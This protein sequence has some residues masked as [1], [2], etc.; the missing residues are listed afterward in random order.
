[1]LPVKGN[2]IPCFCPD[3]SLLRLT[4][5]RPIPMSNVTVIEIYRP[6][7]A[8]GSAIYPV[9][10]PV[11]RGFGREGGRTRLPPPPVSAYLATTSPFSVLYF[12]HYSH[13]WSRR[14][15][16]FCIC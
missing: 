3:R 10:F 13:L 16:H 8:S 15:L 11:S 4:A 1:M 9:F 14:I 2:C 7:A 12:P 6:V 5:K